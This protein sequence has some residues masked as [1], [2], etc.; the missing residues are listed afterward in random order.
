MLSTNFTEYSSQTI[1]NELSHLNISEIHRFTINQNESFRI[2]PKS[3][4][5][6]IG[7]TILRPFLDSSMMLLQKS[8]KILNS[9]FNLLHNQILKINFFSLVKAETIDSENL[10]LYCIDSIC[11]SIIPQKR[12]PDNFINILKFQNE[13]LNS[14][15]QYILDNNLLKNHYSKLLIEYFHK[16][17][18]DLFTQKILKLKSQNQMIDFINEIKETFEYLYNNELFFLLDI[19]N[20]NFNIDKKEVL[21]DSI[22]LFYEKLIKLFNL[23]ESYKFRDKNDWIT[24]IIKFVN[25]FFYQKDESKEFD[26][27]VFKIFDSTL[28]HGS[29]LEHVLFTNIFHPIIVNRILFYIEESMLLPINEEDELLLKKIINQSIDWLLE[30]H[31]AT[32]LFNIINEFER[33]IHS[34]CTLERFIVTFSSNAIELCDKIL[35]F[36]EKK[37]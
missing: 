14:L 7:E 28:I 20:K 30:E 24:E 12:H 5:E 15:I 23:I 17:R 27:I 4:G 33:Y 13:D 18:S 19:K 25:S 6:V 21:K 36:Y 3:F 37:K 22:K 35:S 2:I 31:L 1:Y 11:H 16:S 34:N 8:F 26:E 9:S 10:N 32:S 29:L